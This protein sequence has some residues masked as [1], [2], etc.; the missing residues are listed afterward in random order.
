MGADVQLPGNLTA[1]TIRREGRRLQYA[2][3]A[4]DDFVAIL[5]GIDRIFVEVNCR[6]IADETTA[7][8]DKSRRRR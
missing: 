4:L 8:A 2:G 7:A 3:E 6:R 1:E 5:R